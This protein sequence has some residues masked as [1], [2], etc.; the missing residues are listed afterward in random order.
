[1]TS[2]L[3]FFDTNVLVAA[4]V[5]EHPHHIASLARLA[6]Y[7]AGGGACAAHTLA[8]VYSNLTRFPRGYGIAP[9]DALHILEHIRETF[10]IV[11]LTPRETLLTIEACAELDL[12]GA[13]VYDALLI[14]CARKI[15]ARHIYTHNIK[16]FRLVAPDLT[17]IIVEP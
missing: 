7:G 3:D 12:R 15:K 10:H 6:H 1:M 2:E 14:A 5:G 16:H 17:S 11:A 13:I 4:S 8:E 9:L